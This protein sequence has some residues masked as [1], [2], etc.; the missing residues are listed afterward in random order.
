[1]ER[2]RQGWRNNTKGEL[3]PG[4][5]QTYWRGTVNRRVVTGGGLRR[6]LKHE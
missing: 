2:L 4:S 3:P 6:A 1:L 5:V